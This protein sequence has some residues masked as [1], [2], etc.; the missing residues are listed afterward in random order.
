MIWYFP[1][2][3]S[4]VVPAAVMRDARSGKKGCRTLCGEAKLGCSHPPLLGVLTEGLGFE[5]D[6]MRSAGL[7]VGAALSKMLAMRV[8][9]GDLWF[10]GKVRVALKPLID[11]VPLIGAVKVCS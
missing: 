2:F 8:G 1:S 3:F 6:C 9:V 4:T 11:R 5:G 7:G 10:K